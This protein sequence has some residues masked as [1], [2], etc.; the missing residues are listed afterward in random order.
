M[1]KAKNPSKSVAIRHES[2]LAIHFREFLSEDP[3][4]HWH[5]S[6][7]TG[8]RQLGQVELELDG[9][10]LPF[11]P[12]YELKPSL[13]GLEHLTSRPGASTLLVTPELSPR[14]LNYCKQHGICAID[15]NGRAWLRVPGLLVDRKPLPGRSFSYELEPR[16][17][18]V[19][20]S[21]RI[22][23]CLL[24]DRDRLW[25]QAEILPR[26]QASSG[27]VS[28]I[29]QH[30]ISQGF[31]EKISAREFRLRDH[32]AL[33]DAWAESDHFAKRT[34]TTLYAGYIGSPADLAHNLQKW[35]RSA[36]VS[37]AFTQWIAA[38]AR[39]PYTEP[40]ITSAYVSSLPDQEILHQ[41]GLRRVSEGGKLWLHLPDDEGIFI[42]TQT[43]KELTLVS[44]S[45]IY[46]DLQHTGLR[47]PDQATTLREWEGFCKP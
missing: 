46:L 43:S 6:P 20:K 45:Q 44:D 2:E 14:V 21:A 38:W 32:L 19:G 12:T 27:L 29:I 3:D 15:L 28:R 24:T 36:A 39:H 11:L 33:L 4:L 5:F 9:R 30:L 13:P 7:S 42:E 37:I 16:N 31:V 26:T 34:H 40:V 18:F 25:T 22:V 35:A 17:I 8:L 41:L 1:V 23:R 10:R 47:G